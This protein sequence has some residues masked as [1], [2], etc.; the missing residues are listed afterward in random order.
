MSYISQKI[1]NKSPKKN[2]DAKERQTSIIT[3]NNQESTLNIEAFYFLITDMFN[4][5]SATYTTKILQFIIPSKEQREHQFGKTQISERVERSLEL[6]S[7]DDRIQNLLTTIKKR[8]SLLKLKSYEL[9]QYF[10]QSE[11]RKEIKIFQNQE[12]K[13]F[14][15]LYIILK[16]R[17]NEDKVLELVSNIVSEIY[18]GYLGIAYLILNKITNETLNGKLDEI[19]ETIN[20]RLFKFPDQ[21]DEVFYFRQINTL[22]MHMIKMFLTKYINLDSVDGQGDLSTI[23]SRKHKDSISNQVTVRRKASQVRNLGTLV[24]ILFNLDNYSSYFILEIITKV[25]KV[26]IVSELSLFI[27]NLNAAPKSVV[28]LINLDKTLALSLKTQNQKSSDVIIRPYAEDFIQEM[29]SFFT[30]A[31]YSTYNQDELKKILD[32][33]DPSNSYIKYKLFNQASNMLSYA[34]KELAKDKVSDV[35]YIE[36]YL[37][38]IIANKSSVSYVYCK[39]WKGDRNDTYLFDI[40]PILVGF[41]NKKFSSYKQM[42]VKYRQEVKDNYKSIN[43]ESNESTSKSYKMIIKN[44]VSEL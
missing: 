1:I 34:L 9:E 16:S 36:N 3:L 8:L 12:I 14:V 2:R 35:I 44:L 39:A 38:N 29:N 22:V 21:G 37:D 27:Q 6:Y 20:I 32:Y 13:L 7:D 41:L 5:I 4:F 40:K 17:F 43:A 25:S 18:Q 42:N 33:I 28:L 30:I 15:S 24:D 11:L 19:R 31:L 26:P 10:L 23:T